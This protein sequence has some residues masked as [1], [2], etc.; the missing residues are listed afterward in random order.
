MKIISSLFFGAV[1][2]NQASACTYVSLEGDDGT[3]VASRTME[4]G[5]FDNKPE[6]AFAPAGSEFKSMKLGKKQHQGKSW[7]SDYDIMGMSA[8]NEELEETLFADGVNSEGLTVSFLYHPGTASYE[9]YDQ[10]K[11]ANT[12]TSLDLPSYVLSKC[13]TTREAKLAIENINIVGK[14]NE[15]ISGIVPAHFAIMDATGDEII[16]EFLEKETVIFEET[17]GVMTNS[18]SYDWHLTNLRNYVSMSTHDWE[19][20]ININGMQLQATGY[21]SGLLGLPGDYTPVSRFVRATALRQLSRRTDGGEDTIREAIRILQAF[22][23]PYEKSAEESL[24]DDSWDVMKYG[25]TLWTCA[26]DLKN[27]KMYYRT[28][29]NPSIRVLDLKS[30]DFESMSKLERAFFPLDLDDDVYATDRTPT[31]YTS[32]K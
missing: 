4:W 26:Y 1:L 9:D 2:A 17:V 21:G 3:F 13:K 24:D 18:P 12:I 6:I 14:Y 32:C 10:K 30:T 19:D 11:R 8:M 5:A 22:Q 28:A 31:M 7:T 20:G 29:K 25:S 16:V 15:L 27:L 23:L